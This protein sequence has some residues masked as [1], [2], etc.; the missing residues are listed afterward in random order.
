MATIQRRVVVKE[1]KGLNPAKFFFTTFPIA[2]TET[3]IIN[4]G[5][6]ELGPSGYNLRGQLED[7][8]GVYLACIT[9]WKIRIHKLDACRWNEVYPEV[10]KVLKK[11]LQGDDFMLNEESIFSIAIKRLLTSLRSI[12]S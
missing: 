7:I 11:E 10:I 9:R 5:E 2:N 6:R 3:E 4:A 8:P 12:F 1:G